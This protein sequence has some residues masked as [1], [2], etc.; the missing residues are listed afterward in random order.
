MGRPVPRVTEL[1]ASL[2]DQREALKELEEE[3]IAI[4]AI[5]RNESLFTYVIGIQKQFEAQRIKPPEP[6]PNDMGRGLR[7]KA[8]KRDEQGSPGAMAQS[9]ASRK[10]TAGS[11]NA[12]RAMARSTR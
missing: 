9:S 11:P 8:K 1:L 7:G 4:R 12:R 3:N 10:S 5:M 6:V 2:K